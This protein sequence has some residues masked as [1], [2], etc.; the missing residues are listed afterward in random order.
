LTPNHETLYTHESGLTLAFIEH[1]RDISPM[2]HGLVILLLTSCITLPLSAQSPEGWK[3]RVDRSQNAQDP[4]DR[5][6]L[7]FISKGKGLYVK[8]GPAGTFWNS[9][10]NAAGSY[11]LGATFNLNQPRS[12]TNRCCR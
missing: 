3:M 1:T 5:P 2:R 12:H 11:I 7:T 9:R 6:D 4:D 8:G 10:N